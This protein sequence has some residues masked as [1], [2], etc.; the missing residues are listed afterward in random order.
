M[1][2]SAHSKLRSDCLGKFPNQVRDSPF[3]KFSRK[4]F[5]H[6]LGMKVFVVVGWV[7]RV[8]FLRGEPKSLIPKIDLLSVSDLT[9]LTRKGRKK[10]FKRVTDRH[11]VTICLH[12]LSQISIPLRCIPNGVSWLN[13]TNETK[14]GWLNRVRDT[15]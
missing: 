15:F 10:K 9:S 7:S 8:W 6:W 5:P 3:W 14:R 12:Y 2:S 4:S 11:T 1:A 13:G